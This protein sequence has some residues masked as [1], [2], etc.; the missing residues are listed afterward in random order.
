M[1]RHAVGLPSPIDARLVRRAVPGRDHAWPGDRHP[2]AGTGQI[3][4]DQACPG[5]HDF[6]LFAEVEVLA[7]ARNLI[8]RAEELDDGNHTVAGTYIDDFEV[9]LRDRLVAKRKNDS[10]KLF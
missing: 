3:D 8:G 2:L 10:Q 4:L 9:A 1:N 6:P 7:G 5:R